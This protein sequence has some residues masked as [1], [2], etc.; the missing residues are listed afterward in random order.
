M[1]RLYVP[2]S[3]ARKRRPQPALYLFDGQNVFGDEGSYVG[4]WHLHEVVE[5]L[6]PER[7]EHPVVIGIDHGGDRR[8]EELAPWEAIGNPG[9]ADVFLEWIREVVIPAVHQRVHLA[10]GPEH[11]V[12]GGSSMGGLC[13]LYAHLRHPDRFGGALVMSPAF[14]VV[15]PPLPAFVEAAA[16]PDVSR[17]YLDCGAKERGGQMLRSAERVA[18]LLRAKGY[19]DG[20]DLL[21]KADPRGEHNE[22]FW[23][24]RSPAALE[25]LFQK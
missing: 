5:A 3:A 8:I 22:R 23:R 1:V 9:L 18:G 24:R 17:I 11:V 20:E 16:K 14:A 4:G 2:A 21:W 15:G 13:A 7:A 19:V 12:I 25:F 10:T 6:D